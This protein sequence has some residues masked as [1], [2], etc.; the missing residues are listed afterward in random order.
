MTNPSLKSTRWTR[1]QIRAARLAPLAP[2]LQKRGLELSAR[3][4]GN[5]VLPAYPGLIVKDGCWRWPER[6]LA[7]NAIDFCVQV[8]GLSFHDAM[9]QITGPRPQNTRNPPKASATSMARK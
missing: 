8:L 3:E 6:N 4:T 7:G 2:L 1:E 9:R 5:F